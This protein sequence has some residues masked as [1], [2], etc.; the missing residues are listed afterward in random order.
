MVNTESS[1]VRFHSLEVWWGML[2]RD[3]GKLPSFLQ[4]VKK[5]QE[6]FIIIHQPKHWILFCFSNMT[7][8]ISRSLSKN[9]SSVIVTKNSWRWW[10]ISKLS[11]VYSWQYF[12][13]K[14]EEQMLVGGRKGIQ[15]LFFFLVTSRRCFFVL[16]VFEPLATLPTRLCLHSPASIPASLGKHVGFFTSQ[17]Y[18]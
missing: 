18:Y 10:E 15:M 4:W 11:V 2:G 7:N 14:F 17:P 6:S 1:R 9:M 16:T 3:F 8:A 13:G 5:I 12:S